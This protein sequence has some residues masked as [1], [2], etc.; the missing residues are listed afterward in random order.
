MVK[1]FLPDCRKLSDYKQGL[2]DFCFRYGNGFC[3]SRAFFCGGA[4]FALFNPQ[5]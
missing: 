1:K 4:V 3:G 5:G 2:F